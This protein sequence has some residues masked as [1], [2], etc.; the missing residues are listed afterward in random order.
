MGPGLKKRPMRLRCE[1]DNC[2]IT[3]SSMGMFLS[4]INDHVNKILPTCVNAENYKN[5]DIVLS[6][7]ETEELHC[8]W[9]EC[10]FTST[11][12][13]VTLIRHLYFHAYHAKIK[14]WALQEQSRNSF[15]NCILGSMTRNMIP[16]LPQRFLC[17]WNNCEFFTDNAEHYYRHADNHGMVDDPVM[18]NNQ[19]T[20]PCQWE[21]CETITKTKY[22][23]AEHLRSH[24][25]E[26]RFACND[27]GSLFSN[28]AKFIDHIARQLA[29]ELQNYQCSH[30]SKIFANERLLRD[31][32]RHHVNHY[33]CP[34]CD[35]TC[36]N[37]SMLK[38]HIKWK[39]SSDRPYSCD[40]CDHRCKSTSALRRHVTTH[41]T[42]IMICDEPNCSYTAGTMST[43]KK[44]VMRNH[45]DEKKQPYECHVCNTR[46]SCGAT[47][48]RH[49]KMKHKFKWPSGHS[50]FRYKKQDDG[51]YR[52][53]TV[54]YESLELTEQIL[55]EKQQEQ[56]D[57]VPVEKMT[58]IENNNEDLD[59]DFMD[60]ESTIPDRVD[61]QRLLDETCRLADV[62]ERLESE[63][64]R[65][66]DETGRLADQTERL[67]DHIRST[68]EPNHLEISS[69]WSQSEQ[70]V[71]SDLSLRL[72]D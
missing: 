52:L 17:F 30:C 59:E 8:K 55:K 32:M 28:R 37:P 4:H 33:K 67:A 20:Y 2:T 29:L 40:L 25:Q 14:W 47:L 11:D 12:G 36:I 63:T 13:I 60:E 27:C 72:G 15:G 16:D 21:G 24:T 56:L 62:T 38:S 57:D 44:H 43:M 7:E 69:V 31:H 3:H 18:V 51:L 61:D 70:T 42:N 39:H 10:T 50:R 54:R 35:M 1:W 64:R 48:T 23:L 45:G 41:A 22:K 65:L 71:P 46:Y 68:D 34:K 6:T 66:A 49:L 5:Y 9:A 58:A 53:Q 19:E 26:K